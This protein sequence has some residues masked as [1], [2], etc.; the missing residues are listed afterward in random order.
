MIFT[1]VFA[2]LALF[3]GIV[4]ADGAAIHSC[5]VNINNYTL[6]L[7]TTVSSWDGGLFT[8]LPIV[9]QSA[10]LLGAINNGTS[11]AE[12]SANLT[13]TESITIALDVIKLVTSVNTTLTT[14]MASK[15]KFDHLL[16]SPVILL[17]LQ[18]EKDATAKMSDAILAKVPST[19]QATALSLSAKIDDSFTEAIALYNPFS[20]L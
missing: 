16:L 3:T 4:I 8:T 12:A 1:R 11:T 15:P 17:N 2:P 9:V 5:L 14:I 18:L 6:T 19:L 13:I 7:N 10:T 20:G